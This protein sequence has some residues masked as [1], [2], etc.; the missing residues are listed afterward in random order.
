MKRN[1][2]IIVTVVVKV[3]KVLVATELT[4]VIV[5]KMTVK[6]LTVTNAN[7][8]LTLILKILDKNSSRKKEESKSR[9]FNNSKKCVSSLLKDISK[10][11]INI[12]RIGQ[13]N[14]NSVKNKFILAVEENL[15]I[16]LIT[17]T[18]IDSSFSEDQF[19]NDGF[20]TPY[21]VDKGCHWRRFKIMH[22]TR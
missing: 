10:R 4:T 13:L 21:R 1:S 9:K 18:K 7:F 2:L 11:N 19:K 6:I 14:I 15:N 8:I 16:L 5:I 3:L 12:I 22:K 17:E 20:T